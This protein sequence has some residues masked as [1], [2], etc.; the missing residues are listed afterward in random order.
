MIAS[1]IAVRDQQGSSAVLVV[2]G[3]FDFQNH[4]EFREKVDEMVAAGK[5]L[6]TVD[7]AAVDF[8]DSSALGMLLLARETCRQAGGEVVLARPAQY[9]A[10]VFDLC[11]FDQ[12][13]RIEA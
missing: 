5:T 3:R 4:R 13:F 8:I 7:L 11:R 6:L 2:R 12:I 1:N 10:R 9:V